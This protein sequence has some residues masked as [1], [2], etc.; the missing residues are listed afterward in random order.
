MI[1]RYRD[2]PTNP[3]FGVDAITFDVDVD[4]LTRTALERIEEEPETSFPEDDRHQASA[5]SGASFCF[6][7]T[8]W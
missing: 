8:T 2:F 7:P 4:G 5:M 6:M 3:E 1:V